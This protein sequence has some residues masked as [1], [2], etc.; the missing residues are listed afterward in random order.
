MLDK[1]VEAELKQCGIV[2]PISEC[3][4]CSEEHW[5]DVADIIKRSAVNAGFE[6]TLVSDA[7]DVSVIQK[8]IVQNLY[9]CPVV[10]CDVS[11]RNA[12]VMFELGMRLAFDKPTV[13]IIDDKTPFS[14]DTSPLEHLRYPRDLRFSKIED[15]QKELAKKIFSASVSEGSESFLQSFGPY[16]VADLKVEAAPIS[17]VVLDE[18]LLL[19]KEL[20]NLRLSQNSSERWTHEVSWKSGHDSIKE[21][22]SESGN[23][24]SLVAPLN[25]KNIDTIVLEE[26][27]QSVRSNIHLKSV[28]AKINSDS[29]RL[30][31]SFNKGCGIKTISNV[32]DSLRYIL[33]LV[34]GNDT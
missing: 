6:A 32:R 27:L 19:K 33:N 17:E 18:L 1:P 22:R 12:N 28:E 4:G 3:D 11:G 34:L 2:M 7:D 15:F 29:I 5:R 30:D 14:F 26:L 31:F 20:R 24:F 23:E 21:F 16:K 10:V 13:V 9:S 25:G 8:R